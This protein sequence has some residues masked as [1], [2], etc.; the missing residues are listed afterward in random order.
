MAAIKI[1]IKQWKDDICVC[2]NFLMEGRERREEV[3]TWKGRDMGSWEVGEQTLRSTVIQRVEVWTWVRS[4]HW[5]WITLLNNWSQGQ[6]VVMWCYCFCLG[7]GMTLGSRL[8]E[9]RWEE[10]FTWGWWNSDCEC[11]T[12]PQERQKSPPGPLPHN[13]VCCVTHL[14]CQLK[15]LR[16]HK[17]LIQLKPTTSTP[18]D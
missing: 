4:L 14:C 18:K 16:R 3:G 8:P 11:E 7:C 9:P 2:V 15:V 10:G 17:M 5:R 1:K 6:G 13:G 12:L